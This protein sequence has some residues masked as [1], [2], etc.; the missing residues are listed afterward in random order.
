[1]VDSVVGLFAKTGS[2]VVVT[3]VGSAGSPALADRRTF[4]LCD[5]E[6]SRFLYHH[7]RTLDR[8]EASAFVTHCVKEAA[9]LARAE[10]GA[11]LRDLK[12]ADVH[13]VRGAIVD[14]DKP[15]SAPAL[16]RIL[17]SHSL[18]HAAEGDL[19]RS[20]VVE[21]FERRNIPVEPVPRTDIPKLSPQ[22]EP[23]VSELGRAAGPPWRREHKDA[24]IAALATWG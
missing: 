24:T 19:Y 11:L 21:A 5:D 14:T 3:V 9:R 22:H 1:V 15:F 12:R 7:A 20:V 8:A 16:E 10:V 18:V 13:V 23:I 6:A 17:A 2:A 4:A